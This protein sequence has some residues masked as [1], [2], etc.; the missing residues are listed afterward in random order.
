MA[1][2]DLKLSEKG[3]KALA[4]LQANHGEYTASEL[5]LELDME[6][7]GV[8]A[9]M[10]PLVSNELV[11]TEKRD[12]PFLEEDE[13]GMPTEVLKATKTF[14]VTQDGINFVIE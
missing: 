9:V 4:F 8:H 10:R 13:T 12:I 11:Y 5:A 2:K 6:E 1:K 14:A 7:R 3:S